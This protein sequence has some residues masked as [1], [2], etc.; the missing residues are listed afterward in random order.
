MKPPRE[1]GVCADKGREKAS[2]RGHGWERKV[3]S[4]EVTQEE[5]AVGGRSAP[6]L[7]RPL[8][9][10]VQRPPWTTLVPHPTGGHRWPFTCSAVL[11][12]QPGSTQVHC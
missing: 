9:L 3:R 7:P 5:G 4:R 1:K 6:S 10:L 8:G 2:I 12:R 11:H